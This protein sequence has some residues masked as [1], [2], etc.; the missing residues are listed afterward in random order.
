[1]PP[2]EK[3]PPGG[4]TSA[5]QA[6]QG[7]QPSVGGG[8]A[9][10]FLPSGTCSGECPMDSAN[11]ASAAMS[12]LVL[13]DEVV[14]KSIQGLGYNHFGL[15][16]LIRQWVSLSFTRRSYQLLS[17]AAFVATRC[18][19]SMDDILSNR[20]PFAAMTNSQPMD[21]VPACIL[22]P[23][24]EQNVLGPPLQL[25]EMPWDFLQAMRIDPRLDETT[26]NRWIFIRLT[27]YGKAR[28]YASPAFQRDFATLDEISST[29][30]ANKQEIT[31]LFLPRE[32]KKKLAQPFFNL[33]YLNKEPN[34]A[35]F[36]T[37]NTMGVRLRA[38]QEVLHPECVQS[39]KLVDL[40][41]SYHFVEIQLHPN[42]AQLLV[43]A[44]SSVNKRGISHL[45]EDQ[46]PLMD[47]DFE[48]ADLPMTDELEEWLKLLV[49][50]QQPPTT[51]TTI[52]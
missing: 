24:E 49:D 39:M 51:N 8:I 40:D 7:A 30:I 2:L 33:L 44:S 28:F 43:D 36:C 38:S 37:R 19:I 4:T 45:T 13:E 48:Y 12:R 14:C 6:G 1:M 15:H 10:N 41:N 32:E 18:G 20:S 22:L 34:M 9:P 11:G 46:D 21:F 52:F 26:R 5:T 29:W 50:G 47:D 42:D 31:D 17:R 25:Q 3:D 23:M 16:H 35:V 27:T